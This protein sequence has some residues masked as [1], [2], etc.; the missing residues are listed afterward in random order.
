MLGLLATSSEML[1][2]ISYDTETTG[3]DRHLDNP[4]GSQAGN[5][6]TA[7]DSTFIMPSDRS[8][9]A[10]IKEAK[11]TAAIPASCAYNMD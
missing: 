11:P 1:A 6:D 3:P 9:K 10:S 7:S 4:V 5:Y 2:L 8:L